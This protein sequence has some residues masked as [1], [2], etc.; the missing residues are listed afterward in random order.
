MK[1]T[2]QNPVV[3]IFIEIHFLQKSTPFPNTKSTRY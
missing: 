1:G 2:F 3:E